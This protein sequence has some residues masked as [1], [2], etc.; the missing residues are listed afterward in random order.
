MELMSNEKNSN[1]RFNYWYF[2]EFWGSN[3]SYE[4]S[5][6]HN[7][8]LK[9]RI[10][11]NWRFLHT[12]KI[13]FASHTFSCEIL[14]TSGLRSILWY[15]VTRIT[16]PQLRRELMFP[17]SPNS[18]QLEWHRWNCSTFPTEPWFWTVLYKIIWK[19]LISSQVQVFA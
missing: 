7:C 6:N 19:R 3:L 16:R 11:S 14:M 2:S 9:N 5:R 1:Y 10:R 18:F 8:F 4:L 15:N 12:T 13:F 17:T